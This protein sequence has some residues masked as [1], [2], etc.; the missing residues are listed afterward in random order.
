VVTC[1][2]C[3]KP[4][5]VNESKVCEWNGGK[6]RYVHRRCSKEHV[7][8]PPPGL[9]DC[10]ECAAITRNGGAGCEMAGPD[11]RRCIYFEPRT[12]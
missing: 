4:I 6:V 10:R 8:R 3:G 7:N 9:A 12:P 11:P 5:L 2:P 1:E